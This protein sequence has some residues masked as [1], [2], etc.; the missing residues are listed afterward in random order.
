M[1]VVVRRNRKS[2]QGRFCCLREWPLKAAWQSNC[3][4][5]ALQ[6]FLRSNAALN[7]S[8][9]GFMILEGPARQASDGTTKASRRVLAGQF[10]PFLRRDAL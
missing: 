2:V 10:P 3:H 6:G 7:G 1:Q 5:D 9:G 4:F 8:V